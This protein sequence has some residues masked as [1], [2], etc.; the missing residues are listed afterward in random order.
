VT[1]GTQDAPVGG[2]PLGLPGAVAP[3]RYVGATTGGA[4]ATGTFA[5]GDFCIDE[6]GAVYVCTVLG[7]PGTWV[8]VTGGVQSI[9]AGVNVTLGGTAQNPIVNAAEANPLIPLT[10][11]FES[12][13]RAPGVSTGTLA[14]LTSGEISF[15]VGL[16]IAG[17][18]V[19]KI[20]FWSGTTALVTGTHQWFALYD[21]NLNALC[22]TSDDTNVAWAAA[23]EKSLTVDFQYFAGAWHGVAGTADP[24]T[25][26]ASG[27][28][29]VGIMVAATTVPTLRGSALDG[30]LGPV[31]PAYAGHD[32]THSGQTTPGA[33]P[34]LVDNNAQPGGFPYFLVG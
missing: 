29:Y 18:V 7:T 1:T 28:Y 5:V 21:A 3:T 26:P 16:F 2:F 19:N 17:Q 6:T 12:L 8:A 4:P 31:A 27:V 11:F 25:I 22:A 32:T 20:A 24:F 34:A 15:F 30:T 13:P 23:A 14:A 9:T 33:S 10:F